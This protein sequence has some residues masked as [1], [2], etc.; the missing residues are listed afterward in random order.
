LKTKISLLLIFFYV[1]VN[2]SEVGITLANTHSFVYSYGGVKLWVFVDLNETW[3]VGQNQSI[4]VKLYLEDLGQNK[5]VFLNRIT[6]D[7]WRTSIT[8]V[9]SPNT[10]LDYANKLFEWNLTLNGS[11]IF[12]ELCSSS[13]TRVEFEIRYDIVDSMSTSWPFIVNDHIPIRLNNLSNNGNSWLNPVILVF[14]IVILS[15]LGVSSMILWIKIRRLKT[16]QIL[17]SIVL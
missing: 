13:S 7:V 16:Q 12:Q 6:I 9:A 5:G 2:I 1:S 4:R 15:G 11:E 17:N 14:I 8:H 10:T 3:S